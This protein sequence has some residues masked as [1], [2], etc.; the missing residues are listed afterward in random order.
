MTAMDSDCSVGIGNARFLFMTWTQ[1]D[2]GKQRGDDRF[3]PRR[4]S[5][6]SWAVT[7]ISGADGKV[8]WHVA[9][10]QHLAQVDDTTWCV[11]LYTGHQCLTLQRLHHLRSHLTQDES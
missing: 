4:F 5:S 1:K 3:L 9:K 7:A 2:R 11:P 8:S 6:E 10:Y